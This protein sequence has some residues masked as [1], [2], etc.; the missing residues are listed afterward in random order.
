MMPSEKQVAHLRT[1]EWLE[2]LLQG[3][4]LII[5]LVSSLIADFAA[6]QAPKSA[7]QI[8]LPL[9]LGGGGAFVLA[10]FVFFLKREPARVAKLKQKLESAY[11]EPLAELIKEGRN[12]SKA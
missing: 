10:V 11:L 4:V 6:P 7:Y 8:W 3:L 12:T 1:R 9:A 2:I 5:A